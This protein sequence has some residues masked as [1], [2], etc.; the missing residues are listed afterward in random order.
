MNILTKTAASFGIASM[1]L[2]PLPG[3]SSESYPSRP[4]EFIVPWA[5]GGGGDTF[6]RVVAEHLPRFLGVDIGVINMPG[7]GGTVGLAEASRRASD[8]Y[9]IAQIHEGFVVATAVG[10][11]DVAWTDF[12]PV[13]MVM[14]SPDLIIA[15]ADLEFDTFEGMVAYAQE[16]PN[17]LTVGVILGTI[18]HLYMAMVADAFDLEWRYVGFEGTGEII[19]SVVGGHIDLALGS[20]PSAIQFV[21]N[22]DLV[23][24]ASGS[25]ERVADAPDVPTLVELGADME[26]TLGRGIV[27][28]KD[29]PEDVLAIFE[30]AV[31]EMT[32]DEAFIAH[33]NSL[34]GDVEFR[35]R[36]Q[37]TEHLATVEM[38]VNLLAAEIAP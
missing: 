6:M 24:L 31:R 32:A 15:S 10:L 29:T 26:L 1:A 38:M 33:M 20:I 23:F 14:S 19:R 7:V 5:P 22:G 30:A 16:N 28:P 9:T 21:E 35:D 34:G 4:I 37:F 13:S 12:E 17:T 11:T 27:M 8:G 18:P 3:V 25:R 36:A 2:L